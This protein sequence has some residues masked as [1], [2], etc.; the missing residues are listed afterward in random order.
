MNQA[1]ELLR[2]DPA[3][4]PAVVR[5]KTL[6]ESRGARAEAAAADYVG[7]YAGRRGAMIVD[8]VASRQRRYEKRV[9]PLVA[10]WLAANDE[11]S[12]A[13][14]D[15]NRLG[16]AQYGLSAAEVET[17]ATVARG[18]REFAEREGL[19]DSAEEDRLCRLWAER[20]GPFEH[21]PR[22]DPV[23]GSVKGIGLALWSYMRMRSGANALKVDVRVRK[24]LARLGFSVPAD[25]DHAVLVIVK[26]VAQ[27]VG[28]SLL[29]LDQLLWEAQ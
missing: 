22:L 5:L 14:L 23:V 21:A 2:E 19:T 6:K 28:L 10:E 9:R 20:Y 11:H 4:G 1:L 29:V 27:E 7:V 3:W 16:A 8:V 15:Q 17:I 26:A 12:I 18:F 25:S 24:A 13:A